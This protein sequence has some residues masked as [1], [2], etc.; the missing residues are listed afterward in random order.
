MCSKSQKE[1][2]ESLHSFAH[3]WV[4]RIKPLLYKKGQQII[5]NYSQLE[6]THKTVQCFHSPTK[7]QSQQNQLWQPNTISI[8]FY[9][10]LNW[11]H[12]KIDSFISVL[13]FLYLVN[14]KGIDVFIKELLISLL[15]LHFQFDLCFCFVHLSR[16]PVDLTSSLLFYCIFFLSYF[17]FS[18]FSWCL[19]YLV[20]IWFCSCSLNQNTDF[21]LLL[22]LSQLCFL[23]SCILS[24]FKCSSCFCSLNKTHIFN[25]SLVCVFLFFVFCSP[26]IY[27]FWHLVLNLFPFKPLIILV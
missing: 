6:N 23:Y 27:Q 25:L 19:F 2:K 14:Q 11:D 20:L 3:K 8:L 24:L 26:G 18:C 4:Q 16:D 21:I 1:Q 13:I 12:F 7:Q 10:G 5:Y 15:H 22:S 17:P 9:R